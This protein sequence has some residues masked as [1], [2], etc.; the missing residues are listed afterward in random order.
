[1]H[2]FTIQPQGSGSVRNQRHGAT[3]VSEFS[4]ET[5]GY[6][7]YQ[8]FDGK[9]CNNLIM[10]LFFEIAT[11]SFM[12]VTMVPFLIFVVLAEVTI[13][14][15]VN[16]PLMYKKI[17]ENGQI[18]LLDH[19]NTVTIQSYEKCALPEEPYVVNL[20]EHS[21]V[22]VVYQGRIDYYVSSSGHIEVDIFSSF[23]STHRNPLKNVY[24]LESEDYADLLFIAVIQQY[25]NQKSAMQGNIF[26]RAVILKNFIDFKLRYELSPNY[27]FQHNLPLQTALDYIHGAT[28]VAYQDDIAM[29]YYNRWNPDH[30]LN[31]DFGKYLA[32][33]RVI[34]TEDLANL[35]SNWSGST[36]P[37]IVRIPNSGTIV[38]VKSGLFGILYYFKTS[39]KNTNHIDIFKEFLKTR[40][41]V[42]GKLTYSS[43]IDLTHLSHIS[44]TNLHLVISK[45]VLT[46]DILLG[47]AA[48]WDSFQRSI[49]DTLKEIRSE[50]AEFALKPLQ[51]DREFTIK[52][53]LN[54]LNY[55]ATSDLKEID[56]SLYPEGEHGAINRES[57]PECPGKI[58][59]EALMSHLGNPQEQVESIAIDWWRYTLTFLRGYDNGHICNLQFSLAMT[60]RDRNTRSWLVTENRWDGKTYPFIIPLFLGAGDPGG[61]WITA[62]ALP[63]DSNGLEVRMFDF[64]FHPDLINY[65]HTAE[66]TGRYALWKQL[67]KLNLL[68]FF[69]HYNRDN[70][71][72]TD[73]Y[74]NSA[75]KDI[76]SCGVFT[77]YLME[78][79]KKHSYKTFDEYKNDLDAID[80][81]HI[82]KKRASYYEFYRSQLETDPKFADS[83]DS[84]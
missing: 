50:F 14:Y 80:F 9:N 60:A 68:E 79:F 83:C 77:M 46:S 29:W 45:F 51:A 10:K 35:G 33:S 59:T 13:K 75:Q 20:F 71:K 41:I 3:G 39:L 43:T 47:A 62:V 36:Y 72:I 27:H 1:M 38:F 44:E 52:E 26:S 54:A 4:M 42:I 25:I 17:N 82:L 30:F 57:K 8:R 16:T 61:H 56:L 74:S 53:L 81:D 40:S 69:K 76:T 19:G 58:F 65:K 21:V 31:P 12:V 18:R 23:I 5:L 66:S 49:G 48:K 73:H 15:D 70:V 67:A 2:H 6:L 78:L 7:A 28:S 55:G 34:R 22:A 11:F 63:G 24:P 84:C 37:V 32:E 64:L